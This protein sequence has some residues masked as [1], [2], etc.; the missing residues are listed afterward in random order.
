MKAKDFREEKPKTTI[1]YTNSGRISKPIVKWRETLKTDDEKFLWKSSNP[2][3]DGINTTSE[4]MNVLEWE[5]S[6]S[7]QANSG[8]ISLR[9]V[10]KEEQFKNSK[11]I[12]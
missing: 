12:A 3:I 8:S 2:E 4:V 11:K 10:L 6:L 9:S 5:D 7:K 1:Q